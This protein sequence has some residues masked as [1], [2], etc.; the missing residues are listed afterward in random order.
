MILSCARSVTPLLLSIS[1]CFSR[2]T[3]TAKLR[4]FFFF[5]GWVLHPLTAHLIQT[6]PQEA[7]WELRL[8]CPW[9]ENTPR[10]RSGKTLIR[11]G[12]EWF[13]CCCPL[14]PLI[15]MPPPSYFTV[16]VPIQQLVLGLPQAVTIHILCN[17]S[18]VVIAVDRPLPL[19]ARAL[20]AR[21]EACIY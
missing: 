4:H 3:C 11:L 20:L 1:D 10:S 7:L 13:N 2:F 12:H 5:F 6:E 8:L 9:Q 21:Q 15:C 17:L 16:E 19:S 14:H 18:P